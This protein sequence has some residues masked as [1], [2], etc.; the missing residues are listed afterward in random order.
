MY[1]YPLLDL[2]LGS[3]ASATKSKYS[4]YR[5]KGPELIQMI[6]DENSQSRAAQLASAVTPSLPPGELATAPD[7]QVLR[8]PREPPAPAGGAAG[9]YLQPGFLVAATPSDA[10]AASADPRQSYR[11]RIASKMPIRRYRSGA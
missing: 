4:L 9:T 6:L 10:P 11:S 2:Y 8:L 3:K 5:D 7:P 1:R